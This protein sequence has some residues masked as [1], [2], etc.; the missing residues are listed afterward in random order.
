MVVRTQTPNRHLAREVALC[1]APDID[2]SSLAPSILEI[3]TAADLAEA[4][5]VLDEYGVRDLDHTEWEHVASQTSDDVELGDLD[6]GAA[7]RRGPR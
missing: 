2:V 7:A 1:I 3:L 6:D 5:T 4:M